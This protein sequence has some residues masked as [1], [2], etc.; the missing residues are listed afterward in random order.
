MIKSFIVIAI[1]LILATIAYS[2]M[3]NIVDTEMPEGPEEP[4]EEEE[5]VE[6][7]EEEADP[8]AVQE[9]KTL[10]ER[11][12]DLDNPEEIIIW[13]SLRDYILT[14]ND[15]FTRYTL[16]TST[17]TIRKTTEFPTREQCLG[18]LKEWTKEN[19]G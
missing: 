19:I 15:T 2:M 3:K 6:D 9:Y 18:D 5:I 12:K 13:F 1:V 11:I 4:E 7:D 10:Y 16:G 8:D 14:F 17:R